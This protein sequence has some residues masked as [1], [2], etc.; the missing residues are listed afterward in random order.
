MN[1]SGVMNVVQKL[2][3]ALLFA[4]SPAVNL[5]QQNV[6]SAGG[7]AT[8]T[9]GT[10]SWSA[11]QISCSTW[12]DVTGSLNEGVQQPYEFFNPTG[13]DELASDP[14]LTVFPNPASGDV[15]LK[16]IDRNLKNLDVCVYDM[17]G[18]YLRTISIDTEETTIPMEDLTSSTYFL[19][20]F[21]NNQLLR[22]YKIIKK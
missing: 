15:T 11:A 12:F 10:A 13:I 18:K 19:N 3:F 14:G 21:E 7:E 5:A 6:V 9:G 4:G 17:K 2:F 1:M 22:T 16:V 20:I 8:G